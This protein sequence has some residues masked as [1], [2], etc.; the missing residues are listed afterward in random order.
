MSTEEFDALT[1]PRTDGA[2]IPNAD[3]SDEGFGDSPYCYT[4]HAQQLERELHIA[5]EALNEIA[6]HFKRGQSIADQALSKLE[7]VR[8]ATK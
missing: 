1:T 2:I 8:K 7:S 4:Y 5:E 3:L 6:V